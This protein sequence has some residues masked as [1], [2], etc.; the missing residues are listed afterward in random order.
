[1]RRQGVSVRGTLRGLQGV[2][3]SREPEKRPRLAPGYF[4]Q[5][6]DCLCYYFSLQVGH[7]TL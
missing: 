2:P 7:L 6:V 1:M 4:M 3:L 5:L